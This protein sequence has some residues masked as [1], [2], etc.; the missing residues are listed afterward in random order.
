[1]VLLYAISDYP[2][3]YAVLEMAALFEGFKIS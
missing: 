1:M 3:T 2:T